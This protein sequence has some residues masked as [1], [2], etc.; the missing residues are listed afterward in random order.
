MRPF[1]SYFELSL[2]DPGGNEISEFARLSNEIS[3]LD[4]SL[5]DPGSIDLSLIDP[6]GSEISEFDQLSSEI[7]VLTSA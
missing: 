3:V 6:G 2:I 4:L 5:I 1:E 7:S